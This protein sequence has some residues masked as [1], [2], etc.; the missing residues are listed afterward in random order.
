MASRL[1]PLP[2][3]IEPTPL[4]PS[5]NGGGTAGPIGRLTRRW[6]RNGKASRPFNPEG[7]RCIAASPESRAVYAALRRESAAWPQVE[8]D[9]AAALPEAVFLL[10]DLFH[11]LYEED[12]HLNADVDPA[13]HWNFR[14]VATL[15]QCPEWGRI[16]YKTVGDPVKAALLAC[17]LAEQLAEEALA[18][19]S[20]TKGLRRAWQRLTRGVA[21][22]LSFPVPRELHAAATDE[23]RLHRLSK[24]LRQAGA[25]MAEDEGLRRGWSIC[26]GSRCLH[27]FDDVAQLLDMARSLPWLTELMDALERFQ[28]MLPAA[29]RKARPRGP[30]IARLVGY[31]LGHDLN[32]IAP[33]EAV[34]LTDRHLEGLFYE[35]YEH[36][37]LLQ[38]AYTGPDDDGSGPVVCCMDVSR[39][40]NTSAALGRSR[41]VWTKAIGLA[42]M[43]WSRRSQRAFM[44]I[45]FSSEHELETFVAPPKPDPRVAL[46]MARCD[47]DGGTK[48]EPALERAVDFFAGQPRRQGHLIFITDGEAPLSRRFSQ[49]FR[50]AKIRF[51]IK[52]HTVFIDGHHEPLAGL[53]D[54]VF[55]LQAERIDSW[56][57]AM[58]SI[59]RCLAGDGRSSCPSVRY[60]DGAPSSP[61]QRQ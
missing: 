38:H 27:D 55:H 4:S 52:L 37:R 14:T 26:P 7:A 18:A 61:I 17:R 46:A 59:G 47:F 8:A 35:A 6:A 24:M 42:V 28:T 16:H 12:A 48:F 23:D 58:R 1:P 31:R 20:E 44:G 49:Q 25:Q 34:K 22:P 2:T 30:G 15:L 56:E 41:F 57:G 21:L 32:A 51:G 5:R 19:A 53:S 36:R 29:R 43:D 10:E 60:G 45:C 40:M 39:S 11:A 3:P 13:F 9:L 50:A 54:G 33:E